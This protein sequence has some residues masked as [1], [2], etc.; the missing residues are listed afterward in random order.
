MADFSEVDFV[1][2]RKIKNEAGQLQGLAGRVVEDGEPR[3][4]MLELT[5]PQVIEYI[6]RDGGF[7][8]GLETDTGI[9]RGGD[10]EVLEED[11]EMRLRTVEDTKEK[12]QLIELPEEVIKS[13]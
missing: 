7:C 9:E 11:D 4:Q 2:T 13:N 10:L 8:T 3:D 6:E 1:I 12:Y 5:V